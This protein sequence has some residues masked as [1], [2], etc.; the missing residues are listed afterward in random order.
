VGN[1]L[2]DKSDAT[3]WARPKRQAQVVGD[4]SA[5]QWRGRT[6]DRERRAFAHEAGRLV[7]VAIPVS[8]GVVVLADTP[9]PRQ[10]AT[11]ALLTFI[12]AICLHIGF[13]SSSPSL[14]ALG[15]R[16]SAGRG[17][18]LGLL[19]TA[20]VGLWI[21]WFRLSGSRELLVSVGIFALAVFWE[22][23]ALRH[24]TPAS[25]L[26]IVGWSQGALELVDEIRDSAVGGFTIVGALASAEDKPRY[27]D[28]PMLGSVE[29]LGEVV[30]ETRPDIVV[31]AP[32]R[33]R[34]AAF[35]H[36]L[37]AAESG[38]RV[39]ELAQFYEH[40]FGRVPVRDLTWAWF[41]S[42]LHLYQQPYTSA[43]KRAVDVVGAIVLIVLTLPLYPLLALLV[44]RSPGP[45]V[46]RQERLGEHG[47][48]F[49]MYK[50]RTMYADA[51]PPG[52]AVWAG[53]DDPRV[54]GAGRLMRRLRLDEL[55]QLWNVLKRDMSLVGPRPERPEFL[56]QLREAVPFWTR[57]HLVR[58]GIT[59]WAQV[60]R[61]YTADAG[62]TME[63]LSYDLWY[64]RHRSI[65]VDIAICLRT[66]A[67]LI[68]GDRQA[69]ESPDTA[70]TAATNGQPPER[71]LASSGA[72]EPARKT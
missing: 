48:V 24:I 6:A 70:A 43:A 36:L 54:T 42:V 30:A 63:K 49:T 57:R 26:L 34:P 38:F 37:E 59:G 4:A 68:L 9:A 69:T 31:L 27:G 13:S 32:G 18:L 58:P 40:A 23:I 21:P 41:M 11:A 3:F 46:V 19:A 45:I 10:V 29:N 52:Q 7:A 14:T 66:L 15:P 72:P 67:V 56:D 62:S 50:F 60:R 1:H 16:V 44:R 47:R 35:E 22:G 53:V 64:I 33:N 65:T 61:G 28:I 17:V 71:Q 8:L 5:D 25:R 20:A 55:P 51:E 12:W 39:V 2:I